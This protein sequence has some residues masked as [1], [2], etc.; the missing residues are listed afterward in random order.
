MR[1]GALLHDG[2][3]APALAMMIAVSLSGPARAQAGDSAAAPP[4]LLEAPPAPDEFP[5]GTETGARQIYTP[6]DFARYSPRNALD[7]LERVPGF[8]LEREDPNNEARGLGQASGNVLINGERITSKSSTA[9]DLLSRIPAGNVVRIELAEGASLDIPGLSGRIANVVADTGGLSGQFEW[10][11]Q[12]TTGPASL[13]WG[14]ADFSVSGTS[15]PIEYTIALKNPQFYGG[16]AGP[17]RV[18][19]ADGVVDRRFSTSISHRDQPRL[20]VTA[21]ADLGG[22]VHANVNLSYRWVIQRSGEVEDRLDPTLPAFEE[23]VRTTED[24]HDYEIGGDLDFSL[25]PGRLRLI[26]LESYEHD[27]FA[28]QSI[29][30]REGL[31]DIGTRFIRARD[32]GERIG[33]AEYSWPMWGGNWQASAE[34]AFNRLDNIA[35]LSVLD[36]GGQFVEIAF[37]AGTGGVREDRY[38]AA[39]TY[40]RPL[41]ARLSLQTTL[42]G[43]YSQIAQTGAGA[44]SRTFRR[45]K[46]SLSL[47]WAASQ[48]LD[49][50]LLVARRVDQLSFGDFLGQVNLGDDNTD[51]GNNRLRPEQS[52]EFEL[53]T[54]RDLGA[55]GRA[56]L[57]LFDRR[58]ADFVTIVPIATGGESSGNIAQARSF[59]LELVAT[60][61]TDPIGLAGGQFDITLA[62]EHSRLEDPVSFFG[63]RFDNSQPRNLEIDF[64]HDIPATDWA[65]GLE[66]RDTVYAPYYRVSERGFDYNI[67]TFGAIYVEHKDIAGMTVRLRAGN[68]F[69][70]GVILQRTVYQGP[71]S[72]GIVLFSEDR[73]R[74]LGTVFSLR[75]AGGF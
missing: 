20:S 71:R 69:D 23:R 31:A 57:T 4:D 7:M 72:N 22:D 1:L 2:L 65:Y 63:R 47:A 25:G 66:F 40:S 59:G 60:L 56:T 17:N 26:G 16:S 54:A 36:P 21:K 3:G 48:G 33:R 37:P 42:G 45:P 51:A 12:W 55:W 38:E 34:A 13:R 68:L 11:P 74:K 61:R 14:D 73:R 41:T 62:A 58:Y 46:G 75:V 18:T 64:R 15:G 43:E 5:V 28:T 19:G 32:T 53:E 52:W 67:D 70:G 10:R 49:I 8:T 39:L 50:S 9:R 30:A 29:I 27:D 6:E 35:A 44:L 24:A